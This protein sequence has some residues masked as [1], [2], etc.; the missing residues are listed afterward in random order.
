ME[1][2]LIEVGSVRKTHGYAG[3]IKLAVQA[4]F[5]D[6]VA[7]ASFLFIGV[8][9]ATTLPYEV[10]RLRGADW[11]VALDGIGSR[12]RAA[13]LRGRPIFLKL[14][15]VTDPQAQ[16]PTGE[17]SVYEEYKRFVG[18]ALID[19]EQGEIG[20]IKTIEA[21]PQQSMA[22]VAADEGGEHLVPLNRDLI[23]GIDFTKR[24]VF[25]QLPDGLLEL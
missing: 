14:S 23:R 2:E 7:S 1:V 10:S 3:E 20:A 18:Y 22:T 11:I 12:E 17:A 15:D 19:V 5:E 4:G 25:V 6:D 16:R 8:S 13:E 24:I 21:Y 9:A